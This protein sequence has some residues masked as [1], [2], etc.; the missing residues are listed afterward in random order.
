MWLCPPPS[1]CYTLFIHPRANASTTK[2]SRYE[3][4][5]CSS[6]LP[7]LDLRASHERSRCADLARC[8]RKQ[9][10]RLVVSFVAASA[11]CRFRSAPSPPSSFAEPL[12]KE[13]TPRFCF[14]LASTGCCSGDSAWVAAM[15]PLEPGCCCTGRSGSDASLLIP[16]SAGSARTVHLHSG[17]SLVSPGCCPLSGGRQRLGSVGP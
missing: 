3:T 6:E 1:M 10:P 11:F 7:R 8:R 12:R 5:V 16:W 14:P 4:G 2:R 13:W 15:A 17:P 9:Q